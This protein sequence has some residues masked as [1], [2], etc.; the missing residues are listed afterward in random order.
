MTEPTKE[1]REF[2]NY[3]LRIPCDIR[4]ADNADEPDGATGPHFTSIELTVPGRNRHEAYL[5][6]VDRLARA[7]GLAI[8]TSALMGGHK[9]PQAYW[10][11]I[12]SQSAKK[13]PHV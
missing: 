7:T 11:W 9:E 13:D 6:A 10:D 1:E 12:K 3:T 2:A 4:R 8:G 5:L